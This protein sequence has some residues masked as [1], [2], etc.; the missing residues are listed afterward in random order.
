MHEEW[1]QM[2][3]G[4]E[5]TKRDDGALACAIP[6]DLRAIVRAAMIAS[7]GAEEGAQAALARRMAPRWGCVKD[8]AVKRLQRWFHR[9]KDMASDALALLLEELGLTVVPLTP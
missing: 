2:I 5:P 3:A 7:H 8:S 4:S 1:D 9:Q 6:L